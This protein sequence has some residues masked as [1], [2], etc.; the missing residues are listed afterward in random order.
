VLG[1]G[2]EVVGS[3]DSAGSTL[4]LPDRPVLGESGGSS[5]GGLVGAGVGAESVGGTIRGD[6]AELG[7]AGGAW[8]E[9]AVG[10]DD[11]VLRLRV[12]DP[13]VDGEVRAAAA[14]V[15][16]LPVRS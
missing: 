1:P 10:L 9:A 2:V 16:D 4:V 3:G 14:R 12:V 13:A 15:G 5:N 6:R 8:V 7:H 11:V